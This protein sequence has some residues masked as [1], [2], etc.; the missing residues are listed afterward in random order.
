MYMI[1]T[2]DIV[3]SRHV[4]ILVYD[5]I[6]VVDNHSEHQI[7]SKIWK[8]YLKHKKNPYLEP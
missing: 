3:D 2:Y 4:Y 1:Y 8:T 6:V 5:V 7:L